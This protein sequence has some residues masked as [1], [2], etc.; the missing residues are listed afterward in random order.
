MKILFLS[1]RFETTGGGG[2]GSRAHY[3]ALSKIANEIHVVSLR[4]AKDKADDANKSNKGITR[5]YSR[6]SK[7][8]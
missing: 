2:E 4:S 1:N 6:K 8:H 3:N 5:L 7:K